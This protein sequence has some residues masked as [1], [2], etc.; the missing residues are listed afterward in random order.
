METN[1]K[2][3]KHGDGLFLTAKMVSISKTDLQIDQLYTICTILKNRGIAATPFINDKGTSFLLTEFRDTL[4]NVI[5]ELESPDNKGTQFTIKLSSLQETVKLTLLVPWQ[6]KIIEELYQ[7]RA[8]INVLQNADLKVINKSPNVF[9]ETTPIPNEEEIES[10]IVAYQRYYVFSEYFEGKGLGFGVDIGTSYFTRYS[11]EKYFA[12]GQQKRFFFLKERQS[13]EYK[14]TLLYKGPNGYSRCYFDRYDG[15]TTLASTDSF[16][17]KGKRYENSFDYF[18]KIYPSFDVKPTD[19]VAFVSFKGMGTLPVPAKCLFLTVSTENLT[20]DVNQQDKYTAQQKKNLIDAF[21]KK[22]GNVFGK[23]YQPLLNNYHIPGEAESGIFDMPPIL[24]GEGGRLDSPK[25]KNGY[26]YKKY[27]LNKYYKLKENGCFYVPPMLDREVHFVFPSN[28]ESSVQTQ[29]TDDL[30]KDSSLLTRKKLEATNHSYDKGEHLSIIYELKNNYDKGT[31]VFVFDNNDPSAYYNISQELNGW[32]IIRLTKQ[33]LIRKYSKFKAHPKGKGHW[34]TYISLNAFRIVTELG[35][36]PYIFQGKLSYGAQLIIDVSEKYNYFGLGLLIYA[37]GMTQPLFDY[38]IKP[39]PDSRNDLINSH[40]L[41]KYLTELLSKYT[42]EINTYK[43]K[44]LVLR[45]GIENK[46]EYDV[47]VKV[48]EKL[49]TAKVKGLNGLNS[50]FDFVFIEYHKKSLKSIRLFQDENAKVENPLE[51]T[52]MLINKLKAILMNTGA[53]T[54][55]QG[56]SNP[57]L[58]KS[59]YRNIDLIP[60]LKDIFLT[61]QLNFGSPRVAQKLTYL[62]KR[63]DDLL[64]ERRAQEVI[65][66]K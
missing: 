48:V 49:K 13:T 17:Y 63:I 28:V 11:V 61:S 66:I 65:K 24:Y 5:V 39:N 57:V 37:E 35:C 26:I 6:R 43:I 7:K 22:V 62:A 41:D 1:I 25:Y 36:L 30:I 52:W 45:D 47:F 44:M 50:D 16:T 12:T 29:L 55:T 15:K 18:Q 27:F 58:I 59:N 8:Q 4:T 46:T 19:K 14:G 42:T 33:E 56:T 54:L 60:V 31:V 10:D 38:I 32:K 40:L 51:G 23:N 21:W 34:E 20:E 9:Y 3:V 2:L 64:R 53:G